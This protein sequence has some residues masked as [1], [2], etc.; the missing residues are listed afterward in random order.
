MSILVDAV[1]T[2]SVSLSS[3]SQ[4]TVLSTRFFQAHFATRQSTH[5]EFVVAGTSHGSFSID[6][7]C[8][9]SPY[10]MVDVLLGLDWQSGL[11]DWYSRA[12]GHGHLDNLNVA[13]FLH[14]PLPS[15]T[16]RHPIAPIS[17]PSATST[18]N[19]MFPLSRS[20]RSLPGDTPLGQAI[21][22]APAPS[23][24]SIS[25][26]SVIPNRYIND[27]SGHHSL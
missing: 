17:E 22:P 19:T 25:S 4:R 18:S 16:P 26:Y 5:F 24:S 9:V 10:L 6:L 15:T 12:S 2:S 14:A 21:P 20:T 3:V 7:A 11:R 27:A 13:A 8:S 23:F 1:Y